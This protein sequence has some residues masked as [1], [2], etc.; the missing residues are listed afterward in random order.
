MIAALAS[1]FST[2]KPCLQGRVVLGK[3]DSQG[4]AIALLVR[5]LSAM[6]M[7]VHSSHNYTINMHTLHTLIYQ[8]IYV[9]RRCS[10]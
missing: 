7:Y 2:V 8:T 1:A 5:T 10:L 4:L 6:T 3:V 9:C